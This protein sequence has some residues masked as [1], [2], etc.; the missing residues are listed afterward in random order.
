M[1]GSGMPGAQTPNSSA[2]DEAAN[3]P[4]EAQDSEDMP[5]TPAD[6]PPPEV[7]DERPWFSFFAASQVGMFGLPAGEF[8]PAPDPVDGFGGNFGGLAG[9]DEICTMLARQGNPTDTKTWRA[10]LSTSGFQG[11]PQVDAID[12]IGEGPWF[13]FSGRL[14]AETLEGLLP[15]G[16][17]RPADADAQLAEMFSDEYGDA[18][19]PN[20]QVDNHDTLTGSNSEGRLYT[21]N[22]DNDGRAATCEDWTSNTLQ[23]QQTG[24]GGPG[25][26]GPVPVGHSWPRNNNNGRQWIQE[27]TVRGCEA[28]ASTTPGGGAPQGDFTVGAGGGFGGIYCFALGAVPPDDE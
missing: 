26:G 13:D 3:T 23:G 5:T 11:G 16:D 25:G 17:G 28:G 10:F 15:G 22:T 9:A 24:G 6:P 4:T 21:S 19:Q 2:P 12:R 1:L 27:H 8:S 18:M 7:T 14:F 20:D